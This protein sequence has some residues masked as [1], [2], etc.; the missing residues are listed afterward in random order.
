MTKFQA[1]VQRWSACRLCHLCDGRTQ[2]VLCR[3]KLPCD[4]LMVGEAPGVSEDVIGQPFVGPAGQLLDSVVARAVEMADV[5][6]VR[7]AFTNLCGCLP[8]KTA[9]DHAPPESSI[10]A[11][12]PRLEELVALAHPQLVV[13]VGN[14]ARDWLDRKRSGKLKKERHPVPEG[15]PIIDV[16]H[17]ARVLRS[18]RSQ[19][20]LMRQRMAVTLAE[21]FQELIPF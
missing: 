17:P 15:V 11:C 7:F 10:R 5:V 21:A 20:G 8:D 2:V 13:A 1:H 4:V 18:D 9:E 16:T 19:Q 14:L 12:R 3:G 6:D